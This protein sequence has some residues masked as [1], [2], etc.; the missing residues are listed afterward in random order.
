MI[1]ASKFKFQRD[2]EMFRKVQTLKYT[3]SPQVLNEVQMIETSKTSDALLEK[4]G[5]DLSELVRGCK[6]YDLENN[7][8][9]NSF[10]KIVIAQKESEERAEF[11]RA[12]SPPQ[13][14]AEFVKEGKELGKP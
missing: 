1:D 10:R 4:Y 11:E 7:E 13:V 5:F 6:H 9:I 2:M 3:T 8:Q 12:Q 14:I